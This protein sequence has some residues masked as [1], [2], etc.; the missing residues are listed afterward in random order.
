VGLL[1]Q[2][3]VMDQQSQVLLSFIQRQYFVSASCAAQSVVDIVEGASGSHYQPL[4]ADC[5]AR[6]ITE[7]GDGFGLLGNDGYLAGASDHA[8][9]AANSQ[10]ASPLIRQHSQHVIIAV[11]NV[12]SWLTTLDQDAL[13]ILAGNHDGA[14]AQELA[15]LADQAL[16][17]VDTDGDESIDPI[18]GEAGVVTAYTHG[19]LLALLDLTPPKAA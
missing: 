17:G 6:N 1:Q 7:E 8:S 2:A 3:T 12:T 13:S 4:S 10:D 18:A 14:K 11:T 15:T 19:Q 16:H 5:V 9:L